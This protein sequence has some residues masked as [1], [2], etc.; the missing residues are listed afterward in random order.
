MPARKPKPRESFG[1]LFPEELEAEGFNIIRVRQ[2]PLKRIF[3]DDVMAEKK[4]DG[5]KI[6]NDILIQIMKY[7]KLDKSTILK[8]NK[9]IKKPN[10]QNEKGLEKYIDMILTEKANK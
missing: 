8:I 3:E 7:Y 5:K 2:K 4:Y 10:L 1:D 6:T 9:Y